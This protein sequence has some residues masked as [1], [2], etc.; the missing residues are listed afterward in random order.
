MTRSFTRW[1]GIGVGLFSMVLCGSAQD[2][3]AGAGAGSTPSCQVN[4][5][6]GGSAAM[7]GTIAIDTNVASSDTDY[8]IRLTRSGATH[9]YR[10]HLVT[11]LAGLSYEEMVCRALDPGNT[12]DPVAVQ[13]LVTQVMTDFGLSKTRLVIQDSSISNA[14]PVS[15]NQAILGTNRAGSLADIVI[16][17][18]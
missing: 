9:F 12:T 8:I 4:N 18:Q 3:L 14:E 7:K 17:A 2:A 10:L 6:G 15:A 1:F 11:S 16:Y 5:P 13:A